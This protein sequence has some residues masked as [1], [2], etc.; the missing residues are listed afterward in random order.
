VN[1]P[2]AGPSRERSHPVRPTGGGRLSAEASVAILIATSALL[3]LAG[4]ATTGL[5]YGE[6]YYAA[7]ARHPSLAYFDHPP[8]SI[9]VATASIAVA[10]QAGAV[11]L[12]L[13][14]ILLFGATT[15]LL[16]AIGRRL[17]GPW[18]GFIAALLLNA[19]PVF[20]VS[21]GV[22]L[23]PDGPLMFFWLLCV[24][25]LIHLVLPPP[26]ERPL[27]W[28]AAAGAALGLALLS[29]YTAIFL[30]VGAGL[31]A[32]SRRD[33]RRELVRPGPSLALGIALVCFTPVLVWN[34]QHRW[35]SFLWQSTRGMSEYQGIRLDWVL[36]NIAGQAGELLPWVWLGLVVE[37][38]RGLRPSAPEPRRLLSMLAIAPIILF[39]AV[40]AYAPT[41]QRHFHWA[42]PAYMLLF[43]PLGDT[44]HRVWKRRPRLVGWA[45]AGPVAASLVALTVATTHVATGWLKDVPWLAGRLAGDRDPTVECI[46]FTALE[47]ALARLGVLDRRDV[48]VFSDW[49]FRAGKVDYALGGRA[50][51]L[52]LTETDPRSFAF[53]ER[54]ERWLGKDGIF[55]TTKTLDEVRGR[56]GRYF[57]RIEPLGTV[58]VGRRGK[59]ELTLFLYRGVDF[60]RR[61]PLPY[62]G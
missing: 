23:Q 8:L 46:D 40:A 27:R 38:F 61:Y 51:V 53:F 31:Y 59:D 35:I 39:T 49:W 43:L 10:G 4:A 29:K 13:P 18:P 20:A 48:F 1:A 17:F 14:F 7:C 45:L 54:Q 5:C 37:L 50:P 36:N 22:F 58:S 56:F 42:M 60:L 44:V 62:G 57:A 3:R 6:S 47:P 25:W 34:A 26:P 16:F 11:V 15:W 28:W 32:L 30:V 55:V 41:G 9:L 24:W 33:L 12:R 2:S 21:V 52:A 19:A